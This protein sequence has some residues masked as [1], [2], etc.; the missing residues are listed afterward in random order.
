MARAALRLSLADLACASGVSE[1]TIRRCEAVDGCPQAAELTI[2]RLQAVLEDRGIR[3]VGGQGPMDCPG[4]SLD[5]N[6][7]I[8]TRPQ[9][10]AV[11]A[12]AVKG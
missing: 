9:M 3:F 10:L 1:R 11:S 8:G 7:N 4:I 12:G 5:W 6:P 2:D